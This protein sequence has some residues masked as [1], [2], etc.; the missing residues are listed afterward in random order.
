MVAQVHLDNIE[1]GSL[2]CIRRKRERAVF[3][4]AETRKYYKIWGPNWTQSLCTL[5]GIVRGFYDNK[6]CSALEKLI[7][8][9]TGQRGYIM[10]RGKCY[11]NY[12]QIVENTTL[13]ARKEFVEAVLKNAINAKAIF[14]D[15]TPSNMIVI[16]GK[17]SF[18]DLDAFRSFSLIFHKQKEDFEKF[19]LNVRWK[20]YESALRDVTQ[21]LPLMISELLQVP[22]FDIVDE[23]SFGKILEK[24]L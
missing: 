7:Y 16:D 17:L 4:E 21:K 1:V 2:E 10:K 19:S 13:D 5:E 15:F 6:T 3:Y 8:D 20:P 14:H 12:D 22:V 24:I 18:I 9:D 23:A 11:K